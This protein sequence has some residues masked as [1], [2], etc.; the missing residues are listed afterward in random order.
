MYSKVK[1]FVCLFVLLFA[2]SGTVL[3]A[4]PGLQQDGR[5][6]SQTGYRVDNDVVWDYF[7]SRGGVDT[8]GYPVSETFTFREVPVQIFQRHVLEVVGSQA[9]P[10]NLLDPDIMPINAYGGL[11]F[12]RYDASLAQVAPPPTTPDYGVA[13]QTHLEQTVFNSWQGVSVGFLDY[14][15]SAAPADAGGLRV[16]LALEVWGFPT[17]QPAADPNNSSF[18]Y[19]RFQRG[20]MH[21]DASSGV[22]RGIL[23]GDA[24]KERL[25]DG[26]IGAPGATAVPAAPAAT[27]VPAATATATA[28]S[29]APSAP[30]S[31]GSAAILG[32]EIN[33]G[34]ASRVASRVSEG[35][36]SWVR[37]NAID[38]SAVEAQRGERNWS[39]LSGVESDLQAISQQ[40]ANTI[41][42]VRRTPSWAQKVPGALCGPITQG[43]LDEFAAFMGDLV[44]RYSA[45]PYNVKYWEMGNEVDVDPSLIDPKM[46]FGCWGDQNDAYYGGGYYAEMLKKVYPAIKQA[47]PSAQVVI[48]GL[49]MDCDPTNPP[50]GK[51]CLPSKFLEGILRNGGGQAFDIMAYHSYPL[52]SPNQ[53]DPDLEHVAWQHRGG[54]LLGKLSFIREVMGRYGVNK[55]IQMNEGGLLCHERNTAC[56]SDTFYDAQANY[57]PRMY[58]RAWGN[59]LQNAVWYTLNGPGWRQGG[60]LDGSANPRPAY[61]A[62]K[63]MGNLLGG[64]T[65]KE[66]LSTGTLEGYAFSNGSTEYQVYWTN[67]GSTRS[68]SLPSGTQAVYNKF[69]ESL[70]FSGNISVGQAPIYIQIS[71]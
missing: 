62:L 70:S 14:Y 21:Y 19:Q 48:G 5:Y 52:W 37:Y 15:L 35:S 12:P 32:V 20:I 65:F 38:W 24:F 16:L 68:V 66:T 22:T 47:D 23:L 29:A 64:A 4:K 40:G 25:A 44:R 56:P 67:N 1:Y 42:I 54:S 17:S 43:A 46:P 3:Y 10:L 28:V 60:L 63:F 57:V 41:L 59:G 58:A 8:F 34:T 18:V 51:D 71:R 33:Q 55:P 9:R 61:N 27:A 69:G 2:V 6:F 53:N 45:S 36:V 39:A 26:Q 30:P 7:Q 11:T 31:T 13:V 50:S 49:L